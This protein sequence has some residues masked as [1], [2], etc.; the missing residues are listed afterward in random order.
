M[1]VGFIQLVTTGNEF[2]IF[3]NEPKITFFKIY[4]RRHTN[5]FINNYEI[6]GN[7]IVK[8]NKLS[9]MIPKNG[10]FLGN[11][12]LKIKYD[13]FYSEIFKKYDSLYNTQNTNILNFYDSYNVRTNEFNLDSIN[14]V[15]IIKV[16]FIFQGQIYLSIFCNNLKNENE[17]LDLLKSV[18]G[19]DLQTDRNN[20]F[21]NINEYYKF[22]GFNYFTLSNNFLTNSFAKYL[23]SQIIYQDLQVLRIDITNYKLSINL[24]FGINQ[25]ENFILVTNYIFENAINNAYLKIKIEKY[26][27]YIEITYNNLD[28]IFKI[29]LESLFEL[30][31]QDTKEVDFE[32]IDNKIKSTKFVLKDNTYDFVKKIFLNVNGE[33]IKYYYINNNIERTSFTVY[34]L[35]DTPFFGNFIPNDFNESIINNETNLITVANS[36]NIKLSINLYIRLYISLICKNKISIQEFLQITNYGYNL[37][38]VIIRYNKYLEEFNKKILDILINNKI[39]ILSNETFRRIIYQNNIK[40]SYVIYNKITPFANRKITIFQNILINFYLYFDIIDKFSSKYNV[41]YDITNL[42]IGQLVYISKTSLIGTENGELTKI[43]FRNYY[44]NNNLFKLAQNPENDIPSTNDIILLKDLNSFDINIQNLVLIN[45]MSNYIIIFIIESI[46]IISNIFNKKGFEIY[47]EYGQL[48]NL[49][50]NNDFST[51]IFPLSSSIF[52]SLGNVKDNCPI[53]QNNQIVPNDITIFNTDKTSYFNNILTNVRKNIQNDYQLYNTNFTNTIDVG[54]DTFINN[55]IL[56]VEFNKVSDNYYESTISEENQFNT[57]LIKYFIREAYNTDLIG[58]YSTEIK[59]NLFD[60]FMYQ[61]FIYADDNI[62]NKSF[63]NFKFKKKF[64]TKDGPIYQETSFIDKSVTG[65][66][67]MYNSFVFN[68]NAPYYRI[69]NLFVYLAYLS[70]D[71]AISV[72]LP[73]DLVNLRDITLKF[74]FEFII[75]VNKISN[76]LTSAIKFQTQNINTDLVKNNDLLLIN[77]FLVYDAIN[78][79]NNDYFNYLISLNETNSFFF[80]Y[81]AFY[82]VKNIFAID[83]NDSSILFNQDDSTT[84]TIYQY[85][86]NFDDKV[87]ILF[88][89][90]LELNKKLFSNYD[91]IVDLVN[92]FFNKVNFDYDSIF[93]KISQFYINDKTES[94]LVVDLNTLIKNP[95]YYSCYYTIYSYGAIFDNTNATNVRTINSVF[96]VSTI[97]N[98]YYQGSSIYVKKNLDVKKNLNFVNNLNVTEGF[99]YISILFNELNFSYNAVAFEYYLSL[100]NS[101]NQYIIQNIAYLVNYSVSEFIFRECLNKQ[102]LYVELFNKINNSRITLIETYYFSPITSFTTYNVIIIYLLYLS[103][104]QKCLFADV[105]TFFQTKYSVTQLDFNTFLIE[106]YSVNIYTQCI[107]DFIEIFGR[108]NVLIQFDYSN[109]LINR[110]YTSGDVNIQNYSLKSYFL[111]IFTKEDINSQETNL[112]IFYNQLNPNS[113]V[114]VYGSNSYVFSLN[115]S[116]YTEYNNIVNNF[117]SQYNKILYSLYNGGIVDKTITSNFLSDVSLQKE[118]DGVRRI[119]LNNSLYIIQFNIYTNLLKSSSSGSFQKYYSNN[120]LQIN[121][122]LNNVLFFYQITPTTNYFNTFYNVGCA[123]IIEKE[124]LL[125][126]KESIYNSA[127]Y[128]IDNLVY[129]YSNYL[130]NGIVN[131]IYFEKDLNRIIYLLCTTQAIELSEN[132][133]KSINYLKKNTLYKI[134]RVYNYNNTGLK[135]YKDNTSLYQDIDVFEILNYKNWSDDNSFMKNTWVNKILGIL[136]SDSVSPKSYYKYYLHFKDYVIKNLPLVKDFKLSSGVSVID[137]FAE[138]KNLDELHSLIFSLITSS[139]NFSPYYLYQNII[140]IKNDVDISSFLTVDIDY[141]KKK[142]IIFSYFNYLV[143]SFIHIFLIEYFSYDENLYIEYNID[144]EII[145]VKLKDVIEKVNNRLII[146]NYIAESYKINDDNPNNLIYEIPTTYSNKFEIEY[147]LNITKNAI[148]LGTN[149]LILIEKFI[150]SYNI[151][152]GTTDINTVTTITVNTFNS[153]ISNLLQRLNVVFNIDISLNNLLKLKLTR[154]SINFLNIYMKNIIYDLNNIVDNSNFPSS[155]FVDNIKTY[156]KETNISDINLTLNLSCVLLKDFEITY[157]NL[158]EDINLVIGNIRLGSRYINDLL[159]SFKGITTNFNISIDLILYAIKNSVEVKFNNDTLYTQFLS[160]A[161]NIRYLSLIA[162]ELDNLSICVPN[163][164]DFA[165]GNIDFGKFFPKF[166]TKYYSYLYNYY[167]F[168]INYTVIFPELND[169]LNRLIE[170]SIAINN[171][172]NYD[173]DLYKKLYYTIIYTI[174]SIPFYSTNSIDETSY[175]KMLNNQINLY[176]KFNFGFK[177]NKKNMI[178]NLELQNF[179]N[180]EINLTNYDEIYNYMISLYYYILFMTPIDTNL[181]NSNSDL[182]ILFRTIRKYENYNMVY[183]ANIVNYVF[184]LELA[185]NLIIKTIEL[186]LG[187]KLLYDQLVFNKIIENIIDSIAD[188]NIINDFINYSYGNSSTSADTQKIS[189]DNYVNIIKYKDFLNRLSMAIKELIYYTNN[190]SVERNILNVWAKYIS[191]VPFDFLRIFYNDWVVR[192][193]RMDVDDFSSF[194]FAYLEFYINTFNSKEVPGL[195]NNLAEF[196]LGVL[197]YKNKKNEIIQL[198]MNIVELII[199]GQEISKPDNTLYEKSYNIVSTTVDILSSTFW[200]LINFNYINNTNKQFIDLQLTFYNFY[201]SYIDFINSSQNISTFGNDYNYI[202][203]ISLNNNLLILYRIMIL[204]ITSEYIIYEKYKNMAQYILT[205]CHNYVF[206][207]R[208]I[209][210]IDMRQNI[211]TYFD[212]LNKNIIPNNII[213]NYYKDVQNNSVIDIVNYKIDEFKQPYNNFDYFTIFIYN[214]YINELNITNENEIGKLFINNTILNIINSYSG[215]IYR[216]AMLENLQEGYIKAV[217]KYIIKNIN[218]N[219]SVY[220]NTLGGE[221]YD[222]KNVYLSTKNIIQMFDKTAYKIGDKLVTIF[223]IIYSQIND[224]AT[225]NDIIVILFY[226]NCF[227]TWISTHC[228]DYINNINEI[229]YDFSNLINQ[230][231]LKYL[232]YINQINYGSESDK[233]TSQT[234]N[235]SNQTNN[236]DKLTNLEEFKQLN[237]FFDGLNLILFNTYS[238]FEYINVCYQFFNQILSVFN[239]PDK[240]LIKNSVDFNIK[241]FNGNDFKREI[242]NVITQANNNQIYNDFVPNNKLIAWKYFLGLI[243]DFNDSDVIKAMKSSNGL[244]PINPVN[245]FITYIEFINRGLINDYGVL[246]IFNNINLLFDDEQID[247]V[248]PETY[249]ILLNLFTNLNKYP[250]LASMLGVNLNGENEQYVTNGLTN[251]IKVFNKKTFF[252]PMLFFFQQYKNAIPLIAGMYTNFSINIGLNSYNIFKDAYITNNLTQIN[253]ESAL[254]MNF[255]LVEREERKRI[256]Q[257][258]ID[259]LIE[260]HSQY[261]QNILINEIINDTYGDLVIIRFDFGINQMVKELIWTYTFFINEYKITNRS[262]ENQEINANYYDI[263]NSILNTRFYIDGARRDGVI[264]LSAKNFDGITTNI[265]PSRYHTRANGDNYYNVYSFALEPEQFQPTGAMNLNPYKVFTI[266][267]VLS[268]KGLVDYISNVDTLFGLNKLSIEIDLNTVNYN[269]VRYQSGLSGLLFI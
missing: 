255:I 79:F 20:L 231:I 7:Y 54:Q 230:N 38:N 245:D 175:I 109:I 73:N 184:R 147:L 123:S 164:Y 53:E 178:Q 200:N 120:E 186:K 50:V 251:W 218:L 21:Y 29:S 33:D 138:V 121:I 140:N 216:E 41:T 174:Y 157:P 235:Q 107:N 56:G 40:N 124:N 254:N 137:Y 234:S 100:I 149:L 261:N 34:S 78:I 263:Y 64:C 204:T 62:F 116:F 84:K 114:E 97:Y 58:V 65:L 247:N 180:Q 252:I 25:V 63:Q 211:A 139:D 93:K 202:N 76:P 222:I 134:V 67:P 70:Q 74:M 265:N 262:K 258:P 94:T 91:A 103:Y 206:N 102:L 118:Y 86:Y 133:N 168:D 4:Y 160:R 8:N 221:S 57:N 92:Y 10:D 60:Y 213:N 13:E 106:K 125:I 224:T 223:S 238:N 194:I 66:I 267:I 2:S 14:F 130:N 81:N 72:S 129:F 155:N 239:Y 42:L 264:S 117:I 151:Q 77:N 48:T 1:G 150:S 156:Y 158:L 266:E 30:V 142:I 27:L 127:L 159:E 19:I 182:N 143:Y 185:I 122:L 257:K 44:Y 205:D 37:E 128:P 28:N 145:D 246:K 214:R 169:Y 85:L 167:N 135:I 176:K 192:T 161:N 207:G 197:R 191:G 171:I 71:E 152:I 236:M 49:F 199:F 51:S 215:L 240:K 104:L 189:L 153:T 101:I 181:Q 208:K 132:K 108:A 111:K 83:V 9:F 233:N 219:L 126:V 45:L 80:L 173:L 136:E 87:I 177:I 131:S 226:Y 248:K 112:K 193:F 113:S 32:I 12:Y 119:I 256:C 179:F 201:L 75:F 115:T 55:T 209:N 35:R 268:K 166:F 16:D 17:C 26:T 237:K 59:S 52:I 198:D 225:N 88:L 90:V 3:N 98:K 249:K 96:N 61:L 82:F 89:K 188:V 6:N 105:F 47:T 187:L 39:L 31:F 195:V 227:I 253:V 163:D 110:V 190:L 244:G 144:G 241:T 212:Y 146:N 210:T 259:N 141:L 5:F 269:F 170:N 165:N 162:S 196:L 43:Y 243:V 95:F 232:Q 148:D 172:K 242:N 11:T 154:S 22:Y 69:F 229:I 99:N 217:I 250:A 15:K 228:N 46:R 36:S 68:L 24:K 260:T 23:L 220:K 18:N 203:F 183:R